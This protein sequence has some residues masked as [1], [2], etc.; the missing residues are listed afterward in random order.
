MCRNLFNSVE[1][2]VKAKKNEF[3]FVWSLIIVKIL[4]CS[5]IGQK[6]TV[7]TT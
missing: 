6:F 1:G 3:N 4:D 7:E 2:H 5:P